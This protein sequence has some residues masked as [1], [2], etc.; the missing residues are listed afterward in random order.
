MIK[1]VGKIIDTLVAFFEVPLKLRTVPGSAD[2]VWS[3]IWV[4]VVL[5]AVIQVVIGV[6]AALVGMK[7][8]I[9]A[10]HF[11]QIDLFAANRL[12]WAGPRFTFSRHCAR[13]AAKIDGL[14]TPSDPH[15]RRIIGGYPFKQTS[16]LR[17]SLI[18][19]RF[20]HWQEQFVASSLL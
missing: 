19:E 4:V 18:L 1:I 6:M 9:V 14:I 7:I 10:H 13:N 20:I 16:G 15:F 17:L 11:K 2:G 8:W 12:F 3:V 5:M